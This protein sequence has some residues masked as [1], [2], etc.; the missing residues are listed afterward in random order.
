MFHKVI[1][2]VWAGLGLL[3][4]GGWAPPLAPNPA[5][6]LAAPR[7]HPSGS[8]LGAKMAH[9]FAATGSRHYGHC[10]SDCCA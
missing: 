3:T 10:T 8:V 7:N 1:S 9:I 5:T 4:W 6:A 2:D